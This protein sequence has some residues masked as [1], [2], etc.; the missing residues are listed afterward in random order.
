MD[1]WPVTG[2]VELSAPGTAAGEK[3]TFTVQLADG[4]T[5]AQMLVC[6]NRALSI[7]TVPTVSVAAPVLVTVSVCAGEV[8]PID[9][10]PKARLPGASERAGTASAV[11][12]AATVQLDVT[13][14]V[15]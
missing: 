6:A 2:A 11:K 5:E 1:S 9:W 12:L 15:V 8:V 10:P 14:F 13:G 4:A 3:V 7:D